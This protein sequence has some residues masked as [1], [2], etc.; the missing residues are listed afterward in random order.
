ML[1][2]LVND[3]MYPPLRVVSSPL[4]P[5]PCEECTKSQTKQ[6]DSE[7]HSAGFSFERVDLRWTEL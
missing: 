4:A 7:E 2:S 1:V 5:L 6:K 3:L